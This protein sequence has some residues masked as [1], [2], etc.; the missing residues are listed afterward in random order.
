[1][2]ARCLAAIREMLSLRAPG[3]SALRASH[4][5]VKGVLAGAQHRLGMT[6]PPLSCVAYSEDRSLSPSTGLGVSKR[7]PT[8]IDDSRATDTISTISPGES[9]A[10]WDILCLGLLNAR[11]TPSTHAGPHH[12]IGHGR[13]VLRARAN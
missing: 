13:D 12:A 5:D 8:L 11:C 4:E 9:R 10:S 6:E 7:T 3:K 1:M 2:P